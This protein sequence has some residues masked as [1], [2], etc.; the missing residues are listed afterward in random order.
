VFDQSS[1]ICSVSYD[2]I[3][4]YQLPA[5]QFSPI[6]VK[7]AHCPNGLSTIDAPPR[8]TWAIP[9]GQT[10]TRFVATSLQQ[11]HFMPGGMQSIEA[12]A[13][14]NKLSASWM[15]VAIDFINGAGDLYSLYHQNN[16]DD[17]EG[18]STPRL[19]HYL[20][21]KFSWYVPTVSVEGAGHERNIPGLLA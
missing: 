6:D 19:I 18:A 4:W 10:Q 8:P 21:G 15:A 14:Q 1:S 11:A 17:I 12:V 16:A 2:G 5:G 20:K 3:I 13:R 9:H 7:R